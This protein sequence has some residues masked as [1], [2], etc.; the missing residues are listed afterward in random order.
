MIPETKSMK[1]QM[2]FKPLI[3]LGIVLVLGVA[4]WPIA[5][6]QTQAGDGQTTAAAP[7][8]QGAAQAGDPPLQQPEALP[9]PP[10]PQQPPMQG[11]SEAQ[12][13]QGQY[14]QQGNPQAQGAAPNRA[15]PPQTLTLPAGTVIR[16][17]IGEWLSS[18]RNAIG[19]TFSAELSQP[20]V[21]DGWVVARR[22]Q[23][24][25]GRVSTVKSGGHG[26]ETSQ[27]G[28]ELPTLTLVDGQQ[29]P[30]QTQ[31]FQASGP[32]STDRNV[33]TVGTTTGLGA[34]IGAIAGG[35]TG[36]AIGAGLGATAGIIG[37]MSTS[38]RP[39]V[40]PPE[41]VLSFKLKTPVTISTEKSQMAF[42]PATQSDY[43]SRAPQ[44]RPRMMRPVPA[45]YPYGPYPYP[46]AYAYPYPWYPA[47][48]VGL[49]YYGRFGGWR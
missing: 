27:L 20:L 7:E 3:T 1:E 15:V 9:T 24:E 32:N 38:G 8:S 35:G 4:A 12:P 36:A 42:Q 19:D 28:V 37:V 30:L 22:G 41:A 45:P 21:V 29:L 46:Y 6:Q 31:L 5:A 44:N 33:A 11:Q 49:G 2:R 17:R 10:L 25:T 26:T 39:T 16:V 48:F 43:D 40:I 47:P 34:V 18:D 14:S 13:P 23:S